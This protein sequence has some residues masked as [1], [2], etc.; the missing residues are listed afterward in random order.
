M[1]TP[2]ALPLLD[3]TARQS[4]RDRAFRAGASIWYREDVRLADGAA[5]VAPAVFV[6]YDRRRLRCAIVRTHHDVGRLPRTW[7][8]VDDVFPRHWADDVVDDRPRL[9]WAPPPVP[10]IDASPIALVVALAGAI[11]LAVLAFVLWG[12]R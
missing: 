11:A 5:R 10:A 6:A 9:A 4:A 7:V 12:V 3:L 8:A 2:L 1:T